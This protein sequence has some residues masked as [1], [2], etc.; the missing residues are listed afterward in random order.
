V[1][2]DGVGQKQKGSGGLHTEGGGLDRSCKP[3]V[4]L[5]GKLPCTLAKCFPLK[6]IRVHVVNVYSI[7]FD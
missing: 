1:V 3:Q 2:F 4:C 6:V 5:G 7:I